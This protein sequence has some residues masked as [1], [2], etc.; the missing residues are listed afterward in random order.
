[1]QRINWIDSAKGIGILGI[2][3]THLISW[4]KP[5][6]VE[7]EWIEV[8]S[9]L[10]VICIPLLLFTAGFLVN[11]ES[12]NLKISRKIFEKF[13]FLI[14]PFLLLFWTKFD[15]ELLYLLFFCY[16]LFYA[17]K[18]ILKFKFIKYFVLLITILAAIFSP[19]IQIK[20]IEDFVFFFMYFYLGYLTF[21]IKSRIENKIKFLSFRNYIIIICIIIGLIIAIV[22]LVKFKQDIPHFSMLRGFS[23]VEAIVGILII[24]IFS[25]LVQKIKFIQWTLSWIGNLSIFIY[26]VHPFLIKLGENVL[27]YW[28]NISD[29]NI[30]APIEYFLGICGSV[31]IAIIFRKLQKCFPKF[32]NLV[33]FIFAKEV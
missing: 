3:Y 22:L 26:I 7:Y 12:F 21:G 33:R 10:S 9:L 28:L 31:I 17:I 5:Y 30:I 27:Y 19:Y 15:F 6:P 32:R 24:V 23:L 25:I 18:G 16:I 8:Y 20:L 13:Q 29:F 14:I 4:D 1:M 2:I 11:L